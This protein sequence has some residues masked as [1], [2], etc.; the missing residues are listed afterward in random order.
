MDDF[1]RTV[2]LYF[3][4][5]LLKY[6]TNSNHYF[7][8]ECQTFGGYLTL[9]VMVDLI[10]PIFYFKAIRIFTAIFVNS[11]V[12]GPCPEPGET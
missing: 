9:F 12:G 8:L 3:A 7:A 6:H 4:A 2:F 1:T 5:N 11:S 10:L